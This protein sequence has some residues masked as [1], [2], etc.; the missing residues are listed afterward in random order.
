MQRGIARDISYPEPARYEHSASRE[1]N[2]NSKD[3]GLRQI[4]VKRY[5]EL[6]RP[7]RH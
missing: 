7:G 4:S 2:S 1:T 5:F 6:L 3:D